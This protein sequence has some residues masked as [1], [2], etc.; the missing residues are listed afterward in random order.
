MMRIFQVIENIVY[1]DA[2]SNHSVNIYHIL[3]ENGYETAIYAVHY[4]TRL[5]NEMV[6]PMD[7]LPELR[8]D[9]LIIYQM[10]QRS[11]LN[12]MIP[13]WK[14][15]K[16]C[17]YHNVTPAN[18]F[19]PYDVF[20][21]AFQKRGL[22]E[23]QKLNK[24]FNYV[25]GVSYF[26]CQDLIAMGYDKNK[27]ALFPILIDFSDFYQKPD[28]KVL[29]Q[30]SDDW[31]NILFVGRI[32]P[33]K[34]HEDIIRIF[35]YYKKY[36]NQKSRLIL[37]GSFFNAAYQNCLEKY[38]EALDVKDIIFPGHINFKEILAFYKTSDI[39]LCM[40]EHEGFCVPLLEAMLFDVPI[41][42]YECTAVPETLGECGIL[43]QEKNPAKVSF[44]I[45]QVIK[46]E[47]LK[48]EIIEK[49]R[50]RLG[51]FAFEKVSRKFLE[52]IEKIS[53]E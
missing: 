53:Q 39:F 15:K 3:K 41:I 17:I 11:I 33:N 16:A 5:D 2:I 21:P 4:D 44:M 51:D 52:Q 46:N 19:L 30:Y 34:K 29:N 26:N 49:Q 12:S 40:S 13:A 50:R 37:I 14:C 36:I 7:Q 43:V 45:D 8:E 38:V 23:I 20:Q 9:D 35:T 25:W 6:L 27:L 31:I 48:K 28:E 18:F 22:R 32:A 1:G 10:C 24:V 47:E 42:A